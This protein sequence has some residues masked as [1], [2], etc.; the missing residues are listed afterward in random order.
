MFKNC[1]EIT[2]KRK[3]LFLEY[4]ADNRP[5]IYFLSVRRSFYAKTDNHAGGDADSFECICRGQ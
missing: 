1:I 2:Q 4:I 5:I 3:F